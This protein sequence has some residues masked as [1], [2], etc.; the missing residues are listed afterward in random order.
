MGSRARF[1]LFGLYCLPVVA[2]ASRGVGSRRLV[3]LLRVGHD[4]RR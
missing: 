4:D 1:L 3:D 2:L